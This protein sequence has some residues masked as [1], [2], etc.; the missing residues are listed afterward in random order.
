MFERYSYFIDEL[1]SLKILRTY[2]NIIIKLW[3]IEKL[4]TRN[5]FKEYLILSSLY[6][7]LVFLDHLKRIYSYF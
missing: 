2:H 5:F 7:V 3:F 1:S 6:Y 4:I